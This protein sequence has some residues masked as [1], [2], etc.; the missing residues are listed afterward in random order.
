MKLFQYFRWIL[1]SSD[2]AFI[3]PQELNALNKE[4]ANALSTLTG[5]E[6]NRATY[7]QCFQHLTPSLA[8]FPYPR[9]K[10]IFRSEANDALNKIEADALLVHDKLDEL[11]LIAKESI[12]KAG[13]ARDAAAFTRKELEQTQSKILTLIDQLQAQNSEN[14]SRLVAE[15]RTEFTNE[16]N[17]RSERFQEE[18]N[19]LRDEVSALKSEISGLENKADREL[20][21][22]REQQEERL[23]AYQNM[24]A[25]K[26][27][28]IDKLYQEAGQTVLAGGFAQAAVAE[29][30]R[31]ESD[32]KWAKGSFG[33]A[34]LVLGLLALTDLFRGEFTWIEAV[35]KLPISIILAAPGVYFAGLASKHRKES[36]RLRSL[37]LRIGA[38]DSFVRSVKDDEAT[39]LRA[40]VSQHFFADVE[41]PNVDE[42]GDLISDRFLEAF[43][44]IADKLP[45]VGK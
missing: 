18:I 12:E 6:I 26:Y 40:N 5:A 29:K 34:A 23:V 8:K 38:F 30:N 1:D 15:F 36:Y 19:I 27:A 11:Q 43:G 28:E 2:P 45:S 21:N 35:Y 9:I 22:I 7:D 41:R 20:G 14:L 25:A 16:K 24:A 39:R 32:A 17:S 33:I 10:R 3:A 42:G 31:Y 37:G 13:S 4:L 44:K